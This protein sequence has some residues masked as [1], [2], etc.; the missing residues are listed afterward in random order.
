MR[1]I[2]ARGR[3]SNESSITY[4]GHQWRVR[5]ARPVNE[6]SSLILVLIALFLGSRLPENIGEGP[7]RLILGV[8][9]V[10]VIIWTIIAWRRGEQVFIWQNRKG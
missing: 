5:E 9:W 4:V 3:S 7:F 1:I 6:R 2:D 8:G 10:A